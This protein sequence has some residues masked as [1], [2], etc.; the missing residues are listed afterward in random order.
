[1]LDHIKDEIEKGKHCGEC[2]H[3]SKKYPNRW[4]AMVCNK[5]H[6]VV[7]IKRHDLFYWPAKLMSIDPLS[8]DLHLQFFGDQSEVEV[9]SSSCFLCA[10]MT[11]YQLLTL[12][13]EYLN[14]LKVGG[15]FTNNYSMNIDLFEQFID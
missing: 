13:S 8:G 12:P 6:L 11:T 10:D 4:F 2:Y 5:P 1:M 14:A 7:W 9:L 3:N 15:S